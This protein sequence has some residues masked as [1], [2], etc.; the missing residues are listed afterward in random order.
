MPSLDWNILP[1]ADFFLRPPPRVHV[2]A[3][4]RAMSSKD[5]LRSFQLQLDQVNDGLSLAPDDQELLDL[6]AELT[7]LITL[8]KDQIKQEEQEQ[9]AKQRK[10]QQRKFASVASTTATSSPHSQTASPAPAFTQ[11]GTTSG[12]ENTP[13]P[14]TTSAAAKTT[15]HQVFKVG[16]IV[17]AKWAAGDGA[18][19]PAKITEVTGS[20]AL[21]Y[22]TV[23]FIKWEDTIQILPAYNVRLLADD[24]KRKV[25]AV[26]RSHHDMQPKKVLDPLA[27]EAAEEK[28]RRRLVE[29][30]ELER[31]QRN[32][33]NFAA[34]GPK[35][36]SGA[37]GKSVPI[38][39]NSMFKTP[40]SHQG[41]GNLPLPPFSLFY[42]YFCFLFFY[43]FFVFVRAWLT[44]C[45]LVGVVGSG[46]GMTEH[47]SRVKHKF[48][49]L[50][51]D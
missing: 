25:T 21:P 37:V 40:E 9:E 36:R 41:R 39:S 29:K 17:S 43:L 18:Y 44:F 32:W 35:K 4:S 15:D 31:Q 7:D 8:L 5:D 22:Y 50:D 26:E 23:Q 33:Q 2:A 12:D 10:W 47:G 49:K 48:K 6:K 3:S 16:E 51:E 38:G 14:A 28:K 46:K 30:Q 27:R 13:E 42:F 20:S 1:H 11:T 45:V 34:R 19:Y 24:K